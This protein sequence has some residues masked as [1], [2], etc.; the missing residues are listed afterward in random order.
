MRG[1][2]K[3]QDHNGIRNNAKNLV[4]TTASQLY[5]PMHSHMFFLTHFHPP[6]L[7]FF[8][9]SFNSHMFL[10]EFFSSLIHSSSSCILCVSF[11][12]VCGLL[13]GEV[14]RNGAAQ[15]VVLQMLHTHLGGLITSS[16]L[17]SFHCP[18]PLKSLALAKS[19]V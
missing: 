4:S 17:I 1:L 14:R 16:V 7:I 19:G 13:A 8:S 9:N 5:F 18:S 15:A 12:P 10:H 3:I 2:Q 11:V 6:G